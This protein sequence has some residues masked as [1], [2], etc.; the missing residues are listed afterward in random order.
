MK[1]A[2]KPLSHLSEKIKIIYDTQYELY[3]HFP[4]AC[5]YRNNIMLGNNRIEIIFNSLCIYIL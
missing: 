1:F 5:I 3:N 2:F 4:T